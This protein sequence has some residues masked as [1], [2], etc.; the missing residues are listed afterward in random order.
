MNIKKW[1]LPLKLILFAMG[2]SVELSRIAKAIGCDAAT[3]Q[4]L[5][6]DTM[7][8]VPAGRPWN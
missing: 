8:R 3:T 6:R 2:E 4:K 5:I 7:L 1:K